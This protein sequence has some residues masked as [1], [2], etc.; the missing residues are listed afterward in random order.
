MFFY[1]QGTAQ[2]NHHQCTQHAAKNGEGENG[3]VAEKFFAL[4]ITQKQKT[5]QGKHHTGGNAFTCTTGG[6]NDVVF[7]NSG[8]EQASSQGNG[9]NGNGNRS[10][11][12]EASF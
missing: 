10:T 1:N 6:L 12:S 3:D 4:R 11:H 5:R 7:E 2:W 8:F 9:D